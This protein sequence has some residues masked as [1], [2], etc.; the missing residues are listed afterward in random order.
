MGERET[1]SNE[2]NGG[3]SG[4]EEKNEEKNDILTTHDPILAIHST[5]IILS[6]TYLLETSQGLVE[7]NDTTLA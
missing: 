6:P 7:H 2:I 3:V 5:N 4:K 1:N